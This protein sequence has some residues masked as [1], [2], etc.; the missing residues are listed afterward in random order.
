MYAV[1]AKIIMGIN[2]GIWEQILK[3]ETGQ[4][5]EIHLIIILWILSILPGVGGVI[6]FS[7]GLS[8]GEKFRAPDI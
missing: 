7:T 1:G 5:W 2:T 6:F 3:K 4:I 8:K